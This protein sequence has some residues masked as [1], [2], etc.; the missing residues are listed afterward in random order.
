MDIVVLL[1]LVGFAA[2]GV[3]VAVYIWMGFLLF[4]A[5][6]FL[7]AIVL[8]FILIGWVGD[9]YSIV[10]NRILSKRRMVS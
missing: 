5:W 6:C 9:L 2:V 3:T 4:L 10:R 8:G 1:I 7:W